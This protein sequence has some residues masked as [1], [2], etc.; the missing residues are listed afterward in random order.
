MG[1]AGGPGFPAGGFLRP[2]PDNPPPGAV[3]LL[4]ADGD[5]GEHSQK[6]RVSISVHHLVTDTF[7]APGRNRTYDRQIRNVT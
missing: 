2:L 4:S 1:Q 6:P 7:G 3:L 5:L